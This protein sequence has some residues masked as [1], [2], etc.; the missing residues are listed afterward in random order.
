MTQLLPAQQHHTQEHW[1][2]THIPLHDTR[3]N[4]YKI[5]STNEVVSLNELI[6]SL[7]ELIVSLN[8]IIISLNEIIG[9]PN[10]RR[11]LNECGETIISFGKTMIWRNFF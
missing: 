11:K 10:S 2:T 1:H 6:V 5:V 8:E 7:N 4:L 9:S 3:Y